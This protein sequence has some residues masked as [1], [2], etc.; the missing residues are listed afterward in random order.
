MDLTTRAL[1]DLL[2]AGVRGI[3]PDESLFA[4]G[5][6]WGALYNLAT[7]QAVVPWIVDGVEMLPEALKPG[8][9]DIEPFL[10]DT[11]ST[12][13]NN[14]RMDKF[15]AGA[16]SR[17]AKEGIQAVLVKGQGLARVYP[18]PSHRSSGDVDI[19]LLPEEYDKAR[20]LLLPLC[21]SSEPEMRE[22][23]HQGMS[24]GPMELELHGSVSTLM[25]PALDKAL[26]AMLEEISPSSPLQARR[27]PFPPSVSTS[28]T[29]SPI[30]CTTTGA[31]G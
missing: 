22:I 14:S 9:D 10:A 15:V 16:F 2:K 23:Y 4:S 20:E 18:D 12:E 30:S 29:S 26:N 27:F 31:A 19:L 11:M 17:L 25:S 13:I 8:I 6:D 7:E 21:T 24:F 1:L 5:V 28:S 3:P